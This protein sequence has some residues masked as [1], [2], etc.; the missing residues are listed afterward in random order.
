MHILVC[1]STHALHHYNTPECYLRCKQ[2]TVFWFCSSSFMSSLKIKQNVHAQALS[3]EDT[4]KRLFSLGSNSFDYCTWFKICNILYNQS[5][6][7]LIIHNREVHDS[8]QMFSAYCWISSRHSESLFKAQHTASVEA[9]RCH[10]P[11]YLPGCSRTQFNLGFLESSGV[12][13]SSYSIITNQVILKPLMLGF[14]QTCYQLKSFLK[15]K[16]W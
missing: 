3:Q 2:L 14:S 12:T 5:A 9:G 4:N 11:E 1:K 10:L 8:Q 16:D 15:G 6:F 7:I 13:D